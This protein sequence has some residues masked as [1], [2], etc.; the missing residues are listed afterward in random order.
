MFRFTTRDV[1]W[2]TVVVALAVAWWI[3]RRAQSSDASNRTKKHQAE[4][5]QLESEIANL[6]NLIDQIRLMNSWWKSRP[7]SEAPEASPEPQYTP[8][9]GAK[10]QDGFTLENF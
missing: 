7:R 5:A 3:D 2:L 8:P 1:L 10:L 6:N 9:D 4:V